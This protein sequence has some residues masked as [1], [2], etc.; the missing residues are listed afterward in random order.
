MLSRRSK[1]RRKKRQALT[2]C[3]FP[4]M[5]LALIALPIECACESNRGEQIRTDQP[6]ASETHKEEQGVD[7]APQHDREAE[8]SGMTR[9]E[10][11]VVDYQPGLR[12]D[13]RRPQVEI[14]GEVILRSGELELFAYAKAPIPKEHESIL[15]LRVRPQ[16][17]YEAL[18]LIGLMPGNPVSFDWET[19]TITPA[20]GDAVD[21]L[22]RY[23]SGGRTIEHSV[24]DWM[25]DQER[26]A[27]MRHTHWLFTGSRRDEQ[28]RFAADV[29]GTVVT[30]VN[31]DTALLSLP[32]SKSDSDAALWLRANTD[33]IP[34]KGT[35]VTL[36]LRPAT[37]PTSPT[38]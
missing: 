37:V 33:A 5:A 34:K 9:P 1:D 32:E 22:V 26:G 21:V 13:Y 2:Q 8:R 11:A 24:C 30:V 18:G 6:V 28:G 23:E 20:S 12:I 27:P 14:D 15:L 10:A 29:E 3:R 38:E 31:F 7:S 4:A 17:I 19:Q 35:N 16:H 36:I 25:Y